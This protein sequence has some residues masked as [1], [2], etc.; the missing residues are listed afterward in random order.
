MEEIPTF[1]TIYD[2]QVK[3]LLKEYSNNIIETYIISLET[4]KGTNY[5][6]WK[7]VKKHYKTERD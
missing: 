5:N 2:R 6:L 3:K 1:R 4:T 7:I